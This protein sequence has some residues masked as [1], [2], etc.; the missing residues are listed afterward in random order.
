MQVGRTTGIVVHSGDGVT[1]VSGLIEGAI[2]YGSV[3]RLNIA[4]RDLTDYM[5]KI[6]TE[7]G[8]SF[9]TTAER[10]IVRDIKEKLCYVASNFEEEMTNFNERQDKTYELPDGQVITLGN[11]MFRCPE[12][13]FKP[14]SILLDEENSIG[15][16][17]MVRQCG[18]LSNESYRKDLW[19]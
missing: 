3:K 6:L 19:K 17:E 9:T 4:G 12:T 2:D 1:D 14:Q 13:L 11:E 7:R 10:E 5:M 18:E 8:Y 16:S 15:L